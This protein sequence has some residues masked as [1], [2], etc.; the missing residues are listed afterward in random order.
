MMTVLLV[1]HSDKRTCVND[2]HKTDAPG[3]GRAAQLDAE[4]LLGTLGKVRPGAQ[5]TEP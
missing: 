2:N 4:D 3:S 5:G 1:G